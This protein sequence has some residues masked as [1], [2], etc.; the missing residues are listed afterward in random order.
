MTWISKVKFLVNIRVPSDTKIISVRHFFFKKN[1]HSLATRAQLELF[2]IEMYNY[3]DTLTFIDKIC[4]KSMYIENWPLHG[5][6]RKT[7]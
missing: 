7:T 3:N 1:L 6:G 5:V 2:D 4:V